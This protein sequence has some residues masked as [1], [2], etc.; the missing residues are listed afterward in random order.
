MIRRFGLRVHLRL[1]AAAGLAGLFALSA[2]HQSVAAPTAS[3]IERAAAVVAAVTPPPAHVVEIG[4]DRTTTADGRWTPP[5]HQSLGG[6]GHN[7]WRAPAR[8]STAAS[9]APNARGCAAALVCGYRATAPPAG[10]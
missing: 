10:R 7:A 5:R 6:A 2:V 9:I 3:R 8:V 4:R 1:R